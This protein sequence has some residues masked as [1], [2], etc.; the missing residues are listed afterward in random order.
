[1]MQYNFWSRF[2]SMA[3]LRSYTPGMWMCSKQKY[4]NVHKKLGPRSWLIYISE[5]LA[6]I[7]FAYFSSSPLFCYFS[8]APVFVSL[9]LTRMNWKETPACS[10][11]S[12]PYAT[13]NV[14]VRGPFGLVFFGCLLVTLITFLLVCWS[15]W[16]SMTQQS[17][18]EPPA[19]S[20]PSPANFRF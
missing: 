7:I 8:S 11:P 19:P 6:S 18:A 1:M 14:I 5:L 3:A 2:K 12:S 4:H 16:W 20:P 17:E 15:L 10:R 9:L 13:E